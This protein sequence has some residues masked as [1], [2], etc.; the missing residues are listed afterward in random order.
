M[1]KKNFRTKSSETSIYHV[2]V[3]ER[4]RSAREVMVKT[5]ECGVMEMK[6]LCQGE[7]DQLWSMYL[8]SKVGES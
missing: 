8:R 2:C 3:E 6:I 1:R 5:S 7:S 4:E